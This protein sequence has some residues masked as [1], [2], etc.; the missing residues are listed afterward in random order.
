MW[1]IFS[2]K[3]RSLNSNSK[4]NNK[5]FWKTILNFTFSN[6]P[7]DK[8][9]NNKKKMQYINVL[10]NLG[11]CWEGYGST[12]VTKIQL[13]FRCPIPITEFWSHTNLSIVVWV[14]T[15]PKWKY[16][17]LHSFSAK[18]NKRNY[19]SFQFFLVQTWDIQN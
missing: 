18:N 5:E 11:F 15:F 7:S 10:C 19:F 8:S 17:K 4:S 2:I 13:W 1:G 3:I 16:T 12:A 9:Q 6:L 14:V